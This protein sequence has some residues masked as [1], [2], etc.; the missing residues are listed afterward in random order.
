MPM[1]KPN[2][3]AVALGSFNVDPRTDRAP[4][5]DHEKE[6]L[7]FRQ[8]LWIDQTDLVSLKVVNTAI[9]GNPTLMPGSTM[10]FEYRFHQ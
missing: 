2:W 4:A 3:Q 1:A 7:T 9:E 5:N 8:R 10:T 6:A